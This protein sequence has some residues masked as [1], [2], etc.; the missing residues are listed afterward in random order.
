MLTPEMQAEYQR[1]VT[2]DGFR[3]ML[4][5]VWKM[6]PEGEPVDGTAAA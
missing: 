4:A 3:A 6:T 2:P 5:N 1:S